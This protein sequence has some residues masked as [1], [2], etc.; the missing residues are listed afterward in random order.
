MDAAGVDK[1][2]CGVDAVGKLVA[3]GAQCVGHGAHRVEAFTEFNDVGATVQE[4]ASQDATIVVAAVDGVIQG[5]G[6][7]TDA[8]ASDVLTVSGFDFADQGH[9]T[10]VFR[11][12][13]GTTPS[14]WRREALAR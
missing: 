2:C 3:L 14:A 4:F 8:D 11:R 10:R 13:A 12:H 5:P 1:P 9:L 7:D 6:T